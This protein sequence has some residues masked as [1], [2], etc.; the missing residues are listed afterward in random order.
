MDFIID[1]YIYDSD[2]MILYKRDIDEDK[3]NILKKT[4]AINSEYEKDVRFLKD[5]QTSQISMSKRSIRAAG[6]VPTFN[7]GLRCNYCSQS[8]SEGIIEEITR[9]DVS[10]FIREVIK[11][12]IITAMI[13]KEQA[14]LDFTFTGGGEPTYN[15][16]LFKY[17]VLELEEQSRRKDVKLSLAMTTNGM[18]D[19]QKIEFIICHF[20]KVMVSYDGMPIIQNRNRRTANNSET[21][22]IVS[23]AI[24][25]F[26]SAGVTVTI[27]TTLWQK[28]SY[29]LIDM[30]EHI[31]NEF[32]GID[33]W[34]INPVT[35]AGRAEKIMKKNETLKEA[36]FFDEY[37]RLLK[38]KQKKPSP[39]RISSPIFSSELTGFN[40]GGI[41]AS[42]LEIWLLP[43]KK[44][45]TCIDSSEIIT[46]VGEVRDHKV[47]FY[48][49]FQDPLLK[50]GIMKY[51]E[52]KNCIA[53]RVCGSG[54][55][56]K[57]IR[58]EKSKT[59]MIKWECQME[60]K[61]WKYILQEVISGRIIKGWR[62]YKS[63]DPS[64]RGLDILILNQTY[65]ED[66]E[67]D[68]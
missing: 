2:R 6:I 20:N 30:Y 50:M 44:I 26:I 24:K 14:S 9:E 49:R 4:F 7:C 19:F 64:V 32:A 40:C 8:S 18:L 58:E 39:F 57:H 43:N 11:K 37:L 35:P 27:R 21:N 41:G 34:D 63:D 67:Y 17:A 53:F 28:D 33:V 13:L 16:E 52:C 29:N 10:A 59:G 3:K 60:R 36:S 38:Y 45:T 68:L 5:G 15:W 46:Q 65:E 66:N 1:D 47:V 56:L 25:C 31:R 23:N 55:P 22:A 62:G 61:F 42:V 12:R 48:E 54:C 51:R